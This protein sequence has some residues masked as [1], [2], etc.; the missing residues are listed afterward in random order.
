MI[1]DLIP[2]GGACQLSY[3]AYWADGMPVGELTARRTRQYPVDFGYTSTLVETIEDPALIAASRRLLAGIGFAG[4]VEVEY[5]RDARDGRLAVL[6]VNPRPW[7]WLGLG[8]AAGVDFGAL[9]LGVGPC[10]SA[11]R[12]ARWM[13]LSRD[14]V[15]AIQTMLRGGLSLP[16][17]LASFR[18][19]LVWA[20]YA[21]DDPLPGL[22]ET[23]LVAFRLLRG[24]LPA[25]LGIGR[26]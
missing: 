7:S 13:N 23:P 20:S 26:R 5:K 17:Y 1:Q 4:L 9:C 19:P 24:R 15:A 11:A 12:P 14:S 3:A 10:G 8:A 16:A 18:S 25:L 2:G 6:D 22:A 21:A